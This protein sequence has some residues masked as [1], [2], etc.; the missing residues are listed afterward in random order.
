MRFS[1]VKH[2]ENKDN[3]KKLLYFAQI[4]EELFFYFSLDTYKPSATNSRIL[5]HEALITY[6][7][8]KRGNIQEPN[9]QNILDELIDTLSKDKIAI[10]LTGL[11]LQ[12][13][14]ERLER[15]KN[16]SQ[17]KKDIEKQKNLLEL[18]LYRLSEKEYKELTEKYLIEA[19]EKDEL[20]FD[21]VRNFARAYATILIDIG[22]STS[23]IYQ[24][25]RSFFYIDKKPIAKVEVIRQFLDTFNGE[26][27]T[28]S[29]F[30]KVDKNFNKLNDLC[31]KFQI[32]IIKTIEEL[33]I[34]VFEKFKVKEIED[35]QKEIDQIT[36]DNSETILFFKEI[37]ALDFHSAQKEVHDFLNITNTHY[38]M[39]HHKGKLSISN[40]ILLINQ[41]DKK[42][43]L[44]KTNINA[45]HQCNDLV[46]NRAIE[47]LNEF[48]PQFLAKFISNDL[49]SFRKFYNVA[50]LHSLALDSDAVENQLLNLWISFESLIP[51]NQNENL[52][53]IEN[54]IEKVMPF[55][56][57]SYFQT[58]VYKLSR[59]LRH[60][61]NRIIFRI[62]SNIKG[63]TLENKITK[64]LVLEEYRDAREELLNSSKYFIL[65]KDRV[66]HLSEIL[67]APSKIKNGLEVHKK[68]LEWQLRRIYRSRNLLVHS[69]QKLTYTDILITNLHDYL[70]IVMGKLIELIEDSKI[71]N[72][73]Q[74]FEFVDLK[75]N[76]Y[77]SE[78]EELEE[79]EELDKTS[80]EFINKYF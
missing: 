73:E 11:E 28:Y 8:I 47:K 63:N 16:K 48:M 26:D 42:F 61:D 32:E 56:T 10:E 70:D 6:D 50:M 18:L 68:R 62:I 23:H 5:C 13:I 27:N 75:C 34:F 58:L 66:N 77:L 54:I 22:Y 57:L 19:I 59:D 41:Q 53:N 69:A 3:L 44:A 49:S 38:A 52:S 15:P 43:S 67:S 80:E 37:K 74:G 1:S 29:I 72:I 2:W 35:L 4:F 33:Q 17:P 30:I 36:L 39:F 40:D 79:L 12:K 45:M 31:E 60:W 25:T 20:N 51:F 24:K 55:L 64:L 9:F 76:Q 78:L 65:M 14:I 7:E 46:P 71:A 21:D